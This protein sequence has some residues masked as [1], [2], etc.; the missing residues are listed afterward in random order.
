MI[1]FMKCPHCGGEPQWFVFRQW[2]YD[3]DVDVEQCH[4]C[5]VTGYRQPYRWFYLLLTNTIIYRKYLR[6]KWWLNRRQ[7]DGK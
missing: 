5:E 6:F 4:H 1:K 7:M 2:M 3:C